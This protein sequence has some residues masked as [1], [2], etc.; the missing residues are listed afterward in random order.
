MFNIS[1]FI[2]KSLSVIFKIDG[3]KKKITENLRHEKP[4]CWR[5]GKLNE[6]ISIPT[7]GELYHF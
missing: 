4:Y 3:T 7:L 2:L 5:K 6:K 1:D